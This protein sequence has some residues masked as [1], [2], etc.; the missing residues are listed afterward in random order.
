MEGKIKDERRHF[1]RRKKV[2]IVISVISVIAGGAIV[3]ERS[4]GPEVKSRIRQ[5]LEKPKRAVE[6]AVRM[7]SELLWPEKG[8][9][10]GLTQ[11]DRDMLDLL[12]DIAKLREDSEAPR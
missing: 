11:N 1:G 3:L 12:C 4:L 6:K 10:K 9:K 7:V 5:K 2:M 8:C